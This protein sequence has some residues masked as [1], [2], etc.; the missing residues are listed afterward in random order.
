MLAWY[1]FTTL[2]EIAIPDLS[3]RRSDRALW[4]PGR[5]RPARGRRPRSVQLLT[6]LSNPTVRD[7]IT[8]IR[9][10]D[11]RRPTATRGR[12]ARG[13]SDEGEATRP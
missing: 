8:A 9:P 11:G 10:A 6:A 1:G 12:T 4:L 13:G 5:R 7:V 3:P 2:E